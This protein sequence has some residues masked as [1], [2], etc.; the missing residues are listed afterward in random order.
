M[1]NSETDLGPVDSLIGSLARTHGPLLGGSALWRALGYS[2]AR[3]FSKAVERNTIPV[4]TFRI[5]HRR[6][7]FA[8]THEVILWLYNASQMGRVR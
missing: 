5:P 3:A 4:T 1:T 6:G 2:N 7:R 8:L